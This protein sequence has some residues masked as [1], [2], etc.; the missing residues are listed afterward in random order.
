[1]DYRARKR[2]RGSLA[3]GLAAALLALTAPSAVADSAWLDPHD[4]SG[5]Q[6]RNCP[7]DFV[8]PGN[9]F[10]LGSFLRPDVALAEDGALSAVWT[11]G[12]ISASTTSIASLGRPP[13][14]PYSA[15]DEVA[16]A[17]A[18]GGQVDAGDGEATAAW[19]RSGD[20][21]GAVAP[22]GGTFGSAFPIVSSAQ[23][24]DL[25]V[26][27][28]GAAIATFLKGNQV[29]VSYRPPGGSFGSAE[30]VSAS[31]NDIR[32]VAAEIDA[33]GD[34]VVA[35]I[36]YP[37][38]GTKFL[39]EVVY[40]PAAGPAEASVTLADVAAQNIDVAMNSDGDFAVAWYQVD[41]SDFTSWA[42][43]RPSGATLGPVEPLGAADSFTTDVA[44]NDAGDVLAIWSTNPGTGISTE[45]SFRPAGG[46]FSPAVPF[47]GGAGAVPEV[48]F[49]P[50]G[51][52]LAV[53]LSG[54]Q[55]YSAIR[56]PGGSFGSSQPV[57]S[58]PASG[59][60]VWLSTTLD[61]AGNAAAAWAEY[62]GGNTQTET[63]QARVAGFD[64][65]PPVLSH[66]AVP[67][68]AQPGESL[69]MSADRSDVWSS[70]D[71][72]SWEFG[73]GAKAMG[74]AVTHAYDSPGEYTV[75]ISA[76]DALGQTATAT[77]K[78]VVSNDAGTG[79]GTGGGPGGDEDKPVVRRFHLTH[80]VFRVAR[81][82]T[83]V[84]VSRKVHRGTKF[85]F[86]SSEAGRAVLKIQQ[87]KRGHWRTRRPK[88]KRP[89]VKGK[90][91]IKFTGRYGKRKLK[92]GRY[93]AK[94]RVKD[95]DGNKSA[96]KKARFRI[97]R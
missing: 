24:M 48:D 53:W 15:P 84:T 23:L 76:T 51:D 79:T 90:N 30:P 17:T 19:G 46:S 41:G 91:K 50:D 80:K 82:V 88:L 34:A 8:N 33:N 31:S 11:P 64:G 6:T 77:R 78:V 62:Q 35:W 28:N 40:R 29:N 20:V 26:A 3:S 14:G 4:L 61:P 63:D 54:N 45:W 21:E 16:A 66:I 47:A 58:A 38:S 95:A 10:C 12:D 36:R 42:S 9:Y 67:G 86:K 52:A 74:G 1:M 13:G 72:L 93:R 57:L 94:L 70:V 27:P 96:V 75:E 37:G 5:V 7:P 22:A 25:D 49:W 44:V 81:R 65:A 83:P 89:V 97:V 71:P 43:I 39:P 56:P 55:I 32:N 85:V 60:I 68:S 2:G 92:P 18:S 73:D 87:R 59:Q 69:H